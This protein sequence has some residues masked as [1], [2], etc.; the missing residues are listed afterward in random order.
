M[1]AA[2]EEGAAKSA[3]LT[4]EIKNLEKEVEANIQALAKATALR[5]KQ[6]AEFNA[7]EKDLY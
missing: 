2:I 4:T 3:Q 6:L 1:T 7:E 5:K